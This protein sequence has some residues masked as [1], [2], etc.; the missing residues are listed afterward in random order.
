[1]LA[2]RRA[3]EARELDTVADLL[4]D[5]V[6]LHSP[7]AF[8]PYHGRELVARIINLVASILEDFTFQREIGAESDDDHALVFD[9]RVG[10]LSIQGCDLLHTNADGLI[11]ELTVMMRPLKAV[12]AFEERMRVK[13]EATMPGASSKS[14]KPA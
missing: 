11:D 9:A 6:V 1:M 12:Q 5:D 7:V 10:D 13:F 3:V 2:F 4:T 8:R 14:G